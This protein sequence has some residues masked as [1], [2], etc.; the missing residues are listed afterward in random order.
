MG[1]QENEIHSATI[2]EIANSALITGTTNIKIS[3]QAP[4]EYFGQILENYPNALEGQLIPDMPELWKV[5]S[6]TNFLMSKEVHCRWH[7]CLSR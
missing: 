5:E 6:L 7:K 1:Y 2:N 4:K 3:A